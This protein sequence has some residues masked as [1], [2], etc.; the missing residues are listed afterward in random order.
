LLVG[1][2]V[3]IIQHP[4]PAAITQALMAMVHEGVTAERALEY[5]S[6]QG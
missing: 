4:K 2:K 3:N 6:E 1:E 5:L